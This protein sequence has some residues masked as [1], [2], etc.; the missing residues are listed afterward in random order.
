MPGKRRSR[1]GFVLLILLP[2]AAMTLIAVALVGE[3]ERTEAVAGPAGFQ[4]PPGFAVERAATSGLTEY[5]T[6][7]TFDDR[8]RLFLCESNG[9]N[10]MTTEEMLRS[11][12]HRVRLLE[13]TDGDGMFDR[14]RVFAERIPFAAGVL[15]HGGWLYV[16][17]PPDLLRFQ[18]A[19]GDG[20]AER[21][22][23]VLTGW[24]LNV[25]GATLNGPFLGPDGWL[26]MPDARRGYRIQTREGHVVQGKGGRI[27]RVRPDGT[28]LE[29][30]SAGG[31]DNP[32]ELVFTP[33]G[34]TIGTMTYFTDPKAGERDALMHWVEGGVYP[35]P[36]AVIADDRLPLTGD[37]M[38]VMTKLSR[39][40]PAGL[41]RYRSGSFGSDYAGSLFS[42]Q[43]NTHR[44][45]RHVLTRAGATF[46]TSDSTFLT[47]TDPDFHPTDLVEDADGS[48][49]VV[50]TGGWF[51][52][53][54]PVSRTEKPQV[55][56]ALYRI[57][58]VTSRVD[59]K[60]L[61]GEDID[62]AS[63][64][65]ADLVKHL[66][67]R[68]PAVRDR[69]V[70][71]LVAR[72]DAAVEAV[73]RTLS[74][75][76][77]GAPPP[78]GAPSDASPAS[79]RPT[80]AVFILARIGTPAALASVRAAL[81]HAAVDVRIA[82][83]RA[84]GLTKDTAAVD[85][86]MQLVT[87]DEAA[88]RRQ[89]ATALGQ[90]GDRRAVDALLA[91][92]ADPHDRF[93]EHAIIHALIALRD[94][95]SL[96][97]A[98]GDGR[99]AIRKAALVALDQMPAS[100]LTREQLAPFL[101]APD[102]AL[103]R[104]GMW[105]LSHHPN[106]ADVIVPILRGELT[107]G[108][109]LKAGATESQK[110]GPALA[111]ALSSFCATPPVRALIAELLADAG[112]TR[113]PAESRLLL[114]DVVEG[115]RLTPFP[116]EWGAAVGA[117][118]RSNDAAVR[119]RAVSLVRVRGLGGFEWPL[120]TLAADPA[121]SASLRTAA[122]G[123]LVTTRPQLSQRQFDFLVMQLHP[124]ADATV[125]LAAAD[126]LVAAKLTGDQLIALAH[127]PLPKAG[128]LVRAI[129]VRAFEDSASGAAGHALVKAL[130]ASPHGV[131]SFALGPVQAL[132]TRYPDEVR[133]AA[134]PLLARLQ[135]LREER[136]RR[137]RRL[138]RELPRGDRKNGEK[139]FFDR[140]VACATCH[141]VGKRGGEVG[142]DLTPIGAVRSRHDLLESIIFPS[143]SFVQDYEVMRVQTTQEA[144]VGIVRERTQDSLLVVTGPG[145]NVRL[146]RSRVV[147]TQPSTVS[148][149]PEGLDQ[150]LTTRELADLLA[151]LESLK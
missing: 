128:P 77:G 2:L 148:L 30:L 126:A 91:A 48:L 90:I 72:G 75:R 59:R 58:R 28:G 151:F 16:A 69:A 60:T 47:S 147:S 12:S 138:E 3:R 112:A 131:D 61:R 94:S 83:A 41:L 115:C 87:R 120:T 99:V 68:R 11:P 66:D 62:F 102:P 139:I 10:T 116:A 92:A 124:D 13:D 45:L 133:R 4:V 85:R 103:R 15:W 86:L 1:V 146:P 26:Y 78:P 89:A 149:M 80:S 82:A 79:A 135:R 17:A 140:R 107:R 57:R 39:V 34:E 98:L 22:E 7:A 64:A 36:H 42:V 129:L 19:D 37:L 27:W 132:I 38:P 63:V 46:T 110:W 84:L 145:T 24:T 134:E 44:V 50:D 97:S 81:D 55:R 144:H 73:G 106:W 96:A 18:D 113:P 95:A 54:C 122:L 51:I 142:P 20:V 100:P 117:E 109:G 70:E 118:L 21:R 31:F 150:A 123:A 29:W 76:K 32:V 9:P 101:R 14:G 143:A 49:I 137:L 127:G 43:F 130:L 104:I 121:Q 74:F 141:T 136:V 53:G 8:G 111:A 33:A 88:V 35:K 119:M 71:A 6:F 125:R 40:A 67:D 65:P 93:V 105:A 23:V 25:N 114:I 5:P 56:G 52:K 108:P